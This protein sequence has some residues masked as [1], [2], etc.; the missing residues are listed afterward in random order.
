MRAREKEREAFLFSPFSRRK[1]KTESKKK[2]K[3]E[4]VARRENL[5]F[6]FSRSRHGGST[7][8]APAPRGYSP[9]ECAHVRRAVRG[10]P[11]ACGS[12]PGGRAEAPFGDR[13]R[14]GGRTARRGQG[15]AGPHAR[16]PGRR[17]A[18]AVHVSGEEKMTER[19]TEE[20]GGGNE[21]E[22]E[23]KERGRSIDRS[24]TDGSRSLALLSYR[25]TFL[26]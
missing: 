23:G 22:K 26:Y 4:R 18:S 25:L 3:I 24:S 10:P 9:L 11:P 1:K 15:R 21:R 6:S 7:P 20:S 17:E 5:T 12:R 19:E 2:K 14:R 8:D 16:R 13:R